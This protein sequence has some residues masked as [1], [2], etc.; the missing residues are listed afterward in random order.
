MAANAAPAL[1]VG[2]AFTVI[3]FVAVVVPHEPPL[4]V[5]VNVIDPVS[6]APAV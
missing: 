4:V 6:D 1:A 2:L 3:D 5:K